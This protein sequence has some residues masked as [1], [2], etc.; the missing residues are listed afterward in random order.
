MHWSCIFLAPTH[1]YGLQ[2]WIRC[3][4]RKLMPFVACYMVAGT[5]LT[6]WGRDKMATIFQKTFSNGFLLN[7]N[8]WISINIS[9]KFV[10]RGPISNIP[11][12]VRVM[13]WRLPG[14]KTLS[15]PIMVRLPTHICVTRPQWV[16]S[17]ENCGS[18]CYTVNMINFLQNI[19]KRHPIS[20]CE[21]SILSI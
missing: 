15:E 13:A 2:C 11:T 17:N 9:L 14:D 4:M 7:Q 8:V 1:R 16:K 19:H 20:D 6:H 18:Y 10:P 3:F 5:L 21:M 12:L